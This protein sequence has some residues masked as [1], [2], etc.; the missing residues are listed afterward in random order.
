ML[1][2]MLMVMVLM[3]L[4][5][6]LMEMLL[7]LLL[8]LM[9]ILMRMTLRR[10]GGRGGRERV[11]FDYV[12]T[13]TTVLSLYSFSLIFFYQNINCP[14]PLSTISYPKSTPQKT[15]FWPER[16]FVGLARSAHSI[17]YCIICT[18][19]SATAL[20]LNKEDNSRNPRIAP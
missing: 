14:L 16:L 8:L 12:I 19:K 18:R 17:S 10:K 4:R 15:L 11:R 3:I 2:L 1:M 6:V 5:M 13:Y 20:I 9:M 7:F